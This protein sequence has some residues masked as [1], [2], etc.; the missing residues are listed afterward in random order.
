MPVIQFDKLLNEPRPWRAL[1]TAAERLELDPSDSHAREAAV[2]ASIRLGLK[3]IARELLAG[4]SPALTAEMRE[5]VESLPD[6]RAMT[7]RLIGTCRRNLAVLSARGLGSWEAFG[8]WSESLAAREP[9][10]SLDG[11]V[12]FRDGKTGSIGRWGPIAD[13][14]GVARQFMRDHPVRVEVFPKPMLIEGLATPWLLIEAYR[15]TPR[16][17]DGYSSRLYVGEAEETVALDGLAVAD[18]SRELSDERVEVFVGAGAVDRLRSAL[19]SRI[20]LAP[21]GHFAS[22]TGRGG[23]F[24]RVVEDLLRAQAARLESLRGRVASLYGSR[25][26]TWWARRYTSAPDSGRPMRVL[27]PTSI[28]STFVQ[29]SA[30]DLAESFRGMG[31]DARVLIEPTAHDRLTSLSYLEAL[32]SFEPDLIVS[33]NY[34]RTHLAGAIP[35]TIPVVCWIQDAMPHLFSMETGRSHGDMDFVAGHLFPELFE[36][37]GYPR[38]R[39]LPMP[40][41]ASA[42][43]FTPA[44]VATSLRA[45]FECEIAMASHHS[46]TPEAMH[47]RMCRE[48][49][50]GR[51][52]AVFESL[53]PEVQAAVRE[54]ATQPLL[55]RLHWATQRIIREQLGEADDRT[56]TLLVRQYA[57]PMADRMIRHE[58]LAWAAEIAQRR[59]WRLRLFG[60][61]WEAHPTLAAFAGG[62]L[63]HGEELRASYQC[64]AVHLH[65]SANWPLHQ[66]VMECVLSGGLPVCRVKMDDLG[67]MR[68][69]AL[70]STVAG[71]TPTG[72]DPESGD[73]LYHVIDVP[74]LAMTARAWQHFGVSFPSFVRGSRRN[75]SLLTGAYGD[76]ITIEHLL[77]DPTE[78]MFATPDQFE[79]LV[80]RMLEQ[81]D[82]RLCMSRA[83]AGRVTRQA[84]TDVLA[85]RIASLIRSEMGSFAIS[86]AA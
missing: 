57:Q 81:P 3:S 72:I 77:V 36:Q 33:I 63:A 59:G 31:W 84:T 19:E 12:L 6:D 2:R 15:A 85:D 14:A 23:E 75:A 83:I 41:V 65:V 30:R 24:R 73:A 54:C 76:A 34:P 29:H 79:R 37:F 4:A 20:D 67:M 46:E 40:V 62:E 56:A 8:R 49:G 69:R 70:A 64:A 17:R 26:R 21:V 16:T 53:Y 39:T 80:E 18:L 66:R 10:I 68:N 55:P 27:L 58:T 45:R 38:E 48:A 32:A 9:I 28:Y 82:R 78:V 35:Q 51:T 60:R 61:G 1:A 47:R 52:S 74:C 11:N 44:P 43:K 13:L 50:T 7:D 71:H 25:D 22:F 42:R 5:G 86:R